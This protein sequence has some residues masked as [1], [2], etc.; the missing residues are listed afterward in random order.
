MIKNIMKVFVVLAIAVLAGCAGSSASLAQK[1]NYALIEGERGNP[2]VT[3]GLSMS[4]E[5]LPGAY[6]FKTTPRCGYRDC[7]TRAYRFEAEAGNRYVLRTDEPILVTDRTDPNDR[8]VDKL[9]LVGDEYVTRKEK[10]E[11]DRRVINNI[12]IAT[13]EK[14][15]RRKQSL[16]LIRKVGAKVCKPLGEIIYIGFVENFTEDKIQIRLVDAVLAIN[17]NVKLGSFT[18]NTIWDN[19][20][21]WDICN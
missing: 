20:L 1:K 2:L 3:G 4:M 15:E 17:Y 19:P 8:I 5:V 14:M 18:P 7:P 12:V 13:A 16:P 10:K 9:Y 11:Y 6:E 21:N